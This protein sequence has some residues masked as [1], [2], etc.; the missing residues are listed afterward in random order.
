MTDTASLSSNESEANADEAEEVAPVRPKEN[1]V[2][3][4]GKDEKVRSV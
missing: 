4:N 2:V 3:N 1:R